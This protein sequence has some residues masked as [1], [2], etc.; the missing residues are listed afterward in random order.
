MAFH[1]KEFANSELGRQQYQMMTNARKL[2]SKSDQAGIMANASITDKAWIEIDKS[3][4]Q[5]RD[6]AHG[7]EIVNALDSVVRPVHLGKYAF[8]YGVA[9]DIDQSIAIDM[10][11]GTPVTYDHTEY[12]SDGDPIP[13]RHGGFGV[14]ARHEASFNSI[15]LSLLDDSETAKIRAFHRST[16]GY[17]LNGDSRIVFG[18]YQAQGLLN[19]RNTQKIDLGAGGANI[20]LTDPA[21][22]PQQVESF[23]TNVFAKVVDDNE[24]G[25]VTHLYFSPEI[26]RNLTRSWAIAT[27]TEGQGSVLDRLLPYMS[28]NGTGS[29]HKSYALSGNE[30]LSFKLDRQYIERPVGQGLIVLPRPRIN[31]LSPYNFDIYEAS[32]IT[33]KRDFKGRSGVIYAGVSE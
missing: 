22:T 23:F 13:I 7:M 10:E 26:Y 20:D 9:G 29:I 3:I 19:H 27:N 6:S 16:V 24:L 5:L 30:F 4:V 15:N 31:F 1:I 17:T 21:I 12:D 11:G 25:F 18:G 8:N 33:V 14:N 32:G 2:F 28:V